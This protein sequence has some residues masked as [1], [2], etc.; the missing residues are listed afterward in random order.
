MKTMN[1]P[2]ILLTIFLFNCGDNGN[3][4]KSSATESQNNVSEVVVEYMA[5][6]ADFPNPDRG[7]YRYSATKA[8]NY[9]ALKEEELKGYRNQTMAQKSSYSTVSTLFFRYFILDTF[10]GGAISAEFLAL[11]EADFVTARN[12]GV[13]LIPR[14]TYTTTSRAG[15]CPTGFICPPYGDAPKDIVLGHIAQ[16][17]PLLT[18]NADVIN[19]IQMG[20]IGTWGENYYTDFFGDAST[21]ADQG[22]LL[23]ENWR[24]RIE[25]LKAVLDATPKDIMVQVR[26]PQMKQRYVYGIDATTDSA[27][28]TVTEAFSETD[29]ARIGIHNDCLFASADDFGTYADYGNTATPDAI[30]IENLKP[31]FAE[32]SKYVII[33]GETC[34]DGYSPKNDCSPAGMA[35]TDLRALHYTFLNADYNNEVNNDWVDGGCM[36]DIKKNLGYRFVMKKGS[37][38]S[39]VSAG[40]VLKLSLEIENVGYASPVRE[41]TVNLVLKNKTSGKINFFEFEAD[42]REWFSEVTLAGN[43]ELPSSLPKGDYELFLHLADTYKSISDRREYNIRLANKNVWDEVTGYN[44]LQ[45]T[46]V[47]K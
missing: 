38:P 12:A 16:L 36:E 44:N 28:L 2:F 47:I 46:L 13:K 25:V 32:D 31:Y 33:G 23:D 17:G 37:Y 41:R 24:D 42:V 9:T 11:L 30:D 29:K 4:S 26:Y 40:K 10:I 20:F 45:H 35:D 8:S 21:N 14:F 1:I 19:C 43:F 27:P 22:K 18:K 34:N 7:F 15:D 5:D 3:P 39:E 6:T